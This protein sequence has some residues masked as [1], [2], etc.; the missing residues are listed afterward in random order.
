[1]PV[2]ERYLAVL[3]PPAAVARDRLRRRHVRP[4]R[5]RLRVRGEPARVAARRGA[6]PARSSSPSTSRSLPPDEFP[7]LVA[8]ADDLTAGDNDERFEFALD[9]LVRGLEAMAAA[10]P[11]YN[12][13]SH[14][15]CTRLHAS[16]GAARHPPKGLRG[17]ANR[18]PSRAPPSIHGTRTSR[19]SGRGINHLAGEPLLGQL[20]PRVLGL[21]EPV[22]PHAAQHRLG[23]GE[24]D[25][26]VLDDLEVVA[27]RVAELQA[28]PAPRLDRRPPSRPPAPPR[29]RRRR[30]QAPA[31]V[32]PL[33]PALGERRGTGRPCR[34]RPAG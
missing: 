13:R 34:G 9:L 4:L 12:G 24:L 22:Q 33:A 30:A 7:S 14:D 8:L 11:D 18:P 6:T 1:M 23:L 17:S 19:H 2:L 31:A 32:R 10:H 28:A 20:A 5:G 16:R 26:A 25:V 27:P 3:S 21:L 15:P 29:G